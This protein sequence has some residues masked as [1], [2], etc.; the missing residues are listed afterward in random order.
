MIDALMI[1]GLIGAVGLVNRISARRTRAR[2][3]S[4]EALAVHH[5]LR[6]TGESLLGRKRGRSLRIA[7]E[8]RGSNTRRSILVVQSSLA[9]AL[10]LGLRIDPRGPL[11]TLLATDV[12]TVGDPSFDAR[13]L[14]RT[15]EPERT[16]ALLTPAL[17]QR[18]LE[19][20]AGDADSVG[21]L[22]IRDHDVS[23][24]KRGAVPEP[25]WLDWAIDAVL[26]LASAVEEAQHE[27]PAAAAVAHAV[28]S[29][30]EFAHMH[31][32]AFSRTPLRVWGA[33]EDRH[34]HGGANALLVEAKRE[35]DR[36]ELRAT[37]RFAAPI[38]LGYQLRSRGPLDLL[39]SR[40]FADHELDAAYLLTGTK[41]RLSEFAPPL[42]AALLALRGVVSLDDHRLTV[43]LPK[44]PTD[45]HALMQLVTCMST[46]ATQLSQPAPARGAYR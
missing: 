20:Y 34:S 6:R 8:V 29:W 39:A 2:E 26:V 23:I 36:Y 32:L 15:N 19:A 11:N 31:G 38:E 27:V 12:L 28:E 22:L 37:L 42:R 16:L 25:Q 13:F 10:D 14:T 5:G 45:P 7:H 30:R 33:L 9:A 40:S 44:F 3:A 41:P 46:V 43:R 24:E 17:R 1:L 21:E 35:E 18:M 4:W